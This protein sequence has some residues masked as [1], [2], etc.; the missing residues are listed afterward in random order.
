MEYRTTYRRIDVAV[1][2]AFAMLIP[3]GLVMYVAMRP[4]PDGPVLLPLMFWDAGLTIGCVV[5]IGL[6]AFR[7]H[8]WTIEAN[9]L[10]IVERPKLRFAGAT[11]HAAVRFDQILAVHRLEAGIDRY[12]DLITRAGKLYRMPQAMRMVPGAMVARFGATTSDC[13]AASETLRGVLPAWLPSFA[14]TVVEPAPTA[15]NRPAPGTTLATEESDELHTIPGI[16]VTSSELPSLKTA[17]ARI[18]KPVLTAI[19]G[20]ETTF[21]CRTELA[22]TLAAAASLFHSWWRGCLRYRVRSR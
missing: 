7:E 2:A 13:I 14:E 20:A 6:N 8:S 11:T 5:F 18:C 17:K 10:R 3:F 19:F 4:I 9:G 15:L 12:V 21:T 16:A 22:S 1:P